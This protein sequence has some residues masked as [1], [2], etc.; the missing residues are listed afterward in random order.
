MSTW[1]KLR[2]RLEWFGLGAL[3]LTIPLLPRRAAHALGR[4]LGWA[5]FHLD[6]RGRGTA[7]ENLG[8]VFDGEK[9]PEEIRDLALESYRS[10]ARTV[11]DQF[12]SRRLTRENYERHCE[13]EMD[14]PEAVARARETGAIWVTP[15]YGNFEWIALVMGFRGYR[16]TIVAQDFKNPSLTE[17]YRKNREVSGHEVIPQRGAI[18]RL[19]RNL[20]R[21]GHAAFLTDLTIR[22]SKAATIIECFGR[23]T[24]VTAIHA[25][26]MKRTGLAVIPGICIPKD[27]GGYLIRGFAPLSFGPEDDEHRIAQACWKVFEP[28]IRENPAPWLWMYK[29][30]R[31]LPEGADLP[32]PSYAN[33]NPDFDELRER[34]GRR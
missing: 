31:Y 29:H 14:D 34:V 22:P 11:V 20:K 10:F 6:Q 2:Y 33:P 21:G 24:C 18:M 15:H 25:E 1:K 8:L 17:I 7:L 30:W 16:F 9:S 32:Y 28:V 26:L 19:L 27:D 5:A 23:E 13:F 3:Y 12:W 4:A